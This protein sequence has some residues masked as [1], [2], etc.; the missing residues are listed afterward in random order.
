MVG[1]KKWIGLTLWVMFA[2]LLI[3]ILMITPLLKYGNDCGVMLTIITEKTDKNGMNYQLE[4][5]IAEFSQ[6]Y[7]DITFD[8]TILP[9]DAEERSMLMDK[10]RIQ[11]MSGE[12]PD[13]YLL[14]T[15]STVYYS[16]FA[17]VQVQTLFT[18]VYQAMQTGLFADF[19]AYYDTA[20]TVDGLVEN[21]MD[22]GV[23]GTARYLLPL[24][25][26][27]PV[28]YVFSEDL[29]NY[30]V[31]LDAL[32]DKIPELLAQ[33]AHNQA[34]ACSTLLSWPFIWE[35]GFSEWMDYERCQM[36]LTQ[37]ELS[38]YLV[39]YQ[40][41]L[42]IAGDDYL[43]YSDVNAMQYVLGYA[44]L[45]YKWPAVNIG[46]F[47]EAMEYAAI[48]KAEGK[49][50]KM[51]P[52]RSGHGDLTATITYFGAVG[53]NCKN[54]DLAFQFIRQFLNPDF[55]WE[56]ISDSLAEDTHEGLV[57]SGWPVLA[58]GAVQPLWCVV[59]QQG[60]GSVAGDVKAQSTVRK[61]KAAIRN[62]ELSDNDIPIYHVPIQSVRFPIT[63]SGMEQ[64]M[65]T[66]AREHYSMGKSTVSA[67]NLAEDVWK[68]M[69]WNLGEG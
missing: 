22:A 48:A 45:Y 58:E 46:W 63:A 65:D 29:T 3:G 19:S 68:T 30:A 56:Q 28:M 51:I 40:N 62:M 39:S 13:I 27:Y 11:I 23:I 35:Y 18:D 25:Y 57:A 24:R 67:S 42:T 38:D 61:R 20:V 37:G 47:S 9:A 2:A 49:E 5:A 53:A 10:L 7:P 8:V 54:R 16:N 43:T 44:G 17:N 55:Q 32:P 60:M 41:L 21:V 69:F 33:S 36:I 64:A 50:L 34:L 15:S 4:R 52:L 26:D 12:G 14:P 1:M 59:R 66:I 6:Q 31:D